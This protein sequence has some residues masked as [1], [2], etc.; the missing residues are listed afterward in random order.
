MPHPFLLGKGLVCFPQ[1]LTRPFCSGKANPSEGLF[2]TFSVPLIVKLT[3]WGR[4]PNVFCWLKWKWK[5]RCVRVFGLPAVKPLPSDELRHVEIN[6]GHLGEQLGIWCPNESLL[7]YYAAI[8]LN[9]QEGSESM[10]SVCRWIVLWLICEC[11]SVSL[12]N[13]QQKNK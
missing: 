8:W 11:V 2:L 6:P 13:T 9:T 4:T 10:W 1:R 5:Q 12:S 3:I 7:I